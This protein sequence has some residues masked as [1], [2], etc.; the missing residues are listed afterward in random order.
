MTRSEENY[1]KTI[2]HLGRQ[3]TQE[4][5]TNAIAELMETKPSSVTDMIK[6]LSEKDLVNYK[7]YQGVSLT[8]LG[9]K[10]ALG[11]IRKHRLW[12][13]FLVEKLDFSWD[14]VHEVAEQ[15]E[16]IKSDKLIDSLDRLLAFPKF[17][18][19]GDPIPDKNGG[20]K[21]RDRELLSEVPINSEGVCVG[22]KDSSATFLKFLDKNG[23]ALGNHIT[24][25]EIE[26]FDGSL[27]IDIDGRKM[28]ISHVIASNLYIKTNDKI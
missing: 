21:E 15:L 5:A 1:I 26:E 20:F 18:P 23:I 16:H 19:H 4:V 28:Q 24:V 3:G 12:E 13:V 25:M 8:P 11:I 14:E 27:N 10:T 6:R 17:D 9:N 22:V 2:F 7:R